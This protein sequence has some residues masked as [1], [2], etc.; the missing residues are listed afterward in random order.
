MNDQPRQKKDELKKAVRAKIKGLGLD[1]LFHQ[2]DVTKK[3]EAPFKTKQYT[4]SDQ[5]LN[6]I[7]KLKK[8][9]PLIQTKTLQAKF[10]EFL[11][12]LIRPKISSKLILDIGTSSVKIV[13]FKNVKDQIILNKAI[14]IPIPSIVTSSKEKL[15][16]FITESILQTIDSQTLQSSFIS[17][18]LPRSMAVVKFIQLPTQQEEEIKKMLEFEAE[19]HLPFPALEVETDHHLLLKDDRQSRIVF[20]AVKKDEIT[21]HLAFLKKLN[22]KPDAIEISSMAIYNS[23]LKYFDAQDIY[24]QI[25]IGATYTD[26]NI[27]R[28]KILTFSRGIQW[29][30]KDL[31]L[32]LSRNLNISLDDAEKLKKENGILLTKK[33]SNQT[34]K[35]ISDHTCA[36]ADNLIAGIKRTIESFQLEFGTSSINTIILSGGASKTINLNEYL[37]EHLKLKVILQKPRDDIQIDTSV[38]ILDKFT[39]EFNLPLGLIANQASPQYIE[40]NLLPRKIKYSR[41]IKKQK[42]EKIISIATIAS[43]LLSCLLLPLIIISLRNNTIKK[44]DAYLTRLKP[45]VVQVQDLKG[46]IQ[47]IKDYIS[48]K[49]SCMEIL[50]EISILIPYEITINSFSF[51]KSSSVM[52]IGIAKSHASV[53]GFAEDLNKS[54]LFENAKIIYTR[55]KNTAQ[56]QI[57]DFQIFCELKNLEAK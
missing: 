1:A 38:D 10:I 5:E 56:E 27:I 42:T 25:N 55:K 51:E 57:V 52:L 21:R 50:R 19:Q 41:E 29:G 16:K 22:I 39:P 18:I 48:T 35:V 28:N 47:T 7:E 24:L 33:P 9:I 4:P 53:V 17:T 26:I 8:G 45:Q 31:G 13:L 34:Q 23:A 6:I 49:N 11:Q 3:D 43:L 2:V 30:S 14:H 36:W 37:R 40:L 12:R 32:I 46:K 15:E 44:L 20:A 54:A